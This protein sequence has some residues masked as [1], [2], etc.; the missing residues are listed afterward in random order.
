MVTGDGATEFCGWIV[1]GNVCA[2]DDKAT[3]TEKKRLLAAMPIARIIPL[4]YSISCDDRQ[5]FLDV[6]FVHVGLGPWSLC[7]WALPV[8]GKR[9]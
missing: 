8:P 4:S 2:I 3:A 7:S 9:P 1:L 5:K 6:L